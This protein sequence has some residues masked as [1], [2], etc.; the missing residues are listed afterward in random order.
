MKSQVSHALTILRSCLT[1]LLEY[2]PSS[3]LIEG[4]VSLVRSTTAKDDETF[5]LHKVRI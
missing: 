4:E 2:N 5:G 1:M 3:G